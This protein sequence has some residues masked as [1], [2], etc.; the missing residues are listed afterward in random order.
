[1]DILGYIASFVMGITLGLLGGGGS[2][3][4]IPIMVYFF[5]LSPIVATGYS[6][7]IVGVTSLFGSVM[8]IR[9]REIDLG[10][11]V[12]FGIPSLVG[13]NISRGLILP[14]LPSIIVEFGDFALS[15]DMLVMA[16]FAILMLIASRSMI[17]R[18]TEQVPKAHRPIL[19][20]TMLAL[21]GLAIGLVVGFIGAGGGFLI[22]PAL[23]ILGG[24]T[25][26]V[27]IGTSLT[28][29]ALQSLVGFAAD[30]TRDAVID[31]SLLGTVAAIAIFGIFTGASITHLVKE[32]NLK[33]AFGW[34]VLAMGT[35]ILIEQIYYLSLS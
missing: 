6:L 30:L 24:L 2:I 25:M 20:L 11:V 14:R 23:V 9:K 8:Y 16:T 31:R 17:Q 12:S 33:T 28:I 18:S 29:I 26:R 15:K 4:T 21:E 10:A 34:F 1:M 32:Q 7:F 3:L 27:A 22:I 35:V 19:R 5:G 13:V